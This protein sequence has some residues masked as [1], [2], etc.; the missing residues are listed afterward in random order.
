MI[1]FLM[2]IHVI[3]AV[4]LIIVILLQQTRG[5]G[6]GGVFGGAQNVF[7]GKGAQPFFLKATA[8]LGALFMLSSISIAYAVAN[9]GKV[10]PPAPPPVEQQAPEQV[11]QGT[12]QTPQQGG[13]QTPEVP[14][15][16]Q[17]IPQLPL[18]P[19]GGK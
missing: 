15:A 7:G 4:L 14:K 16:G 3:L 13:Q 1:G 17:E 12:E 2:T 8:I 9:R 6:L 18:T 10:R 11:P 5:G 19:E